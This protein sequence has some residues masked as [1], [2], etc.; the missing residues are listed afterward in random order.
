[1]IIIFKPMLCSFLQRSICSRCG[2]IQPLFC[3]LCFLL[4]ISVEDLTFDSGRSIFKPV[5]IRLDLRLG[6]PRGESCILFATPFLSELFL[7]GVIADNLSR[8]G[9]GLIGTFLFTF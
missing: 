6:L 3:K 5:L 9:Q 4:K 8:A 7:F 2:R 1:V